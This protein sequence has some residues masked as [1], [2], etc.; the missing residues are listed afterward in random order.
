LNVCLG[1]PAAASALTSA[2]PSSTPTPR[3]RDLIAALDEAGRLREQIADSK[4]VEEVLVDT[5]RELAAAQGAADEVAY[6]RAQIQRATR[7]VIE[8]RRELL[9]ARAARSEAAAAAAAAPEADGAGTVA[10]APASEFWGPSDAAE[11][12]RMAR[13]R[14]VAAA[15]TD[16]DLMQVC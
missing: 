12:P 6:L 15:P 13:G 5:R 4:S 16:D 1:R 8:L 7:Q 10:E 9:D 11:T 14:G 3:Q 2:P